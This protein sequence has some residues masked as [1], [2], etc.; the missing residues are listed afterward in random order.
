MRLRVLTLALCLLGG[1]GTAH[2]ARPGSDAAQIRRLEARQAAAWNAHDA[3]AYAALFTPDGDVVNV[4]GWWWKGRDQIEAKLRAAF[5]FVFANSR[6]A[7]D[8]VDSRKLGDGI[9]IAHV[10]WTLTGARAPGAALPV[11]QQGI[12]TQV[13]VKQGGRW[14]I[15]AFQNTNAVP[16]TPFPSGP[17]AKP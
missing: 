15:D 8:S 17:P 2:A 5:A 7:I 6:L 10:R 9:A 4:V 16:E 13:L 11:P 3:P 12:Q 1:V 14:F